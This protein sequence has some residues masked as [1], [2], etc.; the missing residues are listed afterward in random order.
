LGQ[1]VVGYDISFIPRLL[2]TFLGSGI[3]VLGFS[4]LQIALQIVIAD[5]TTLQWRPIVST[6]S[7]GGWYLCVFTVSSAFFTDS[8]STVLTS[9]LYLFSFILWVYG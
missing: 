7:T 2:L 6:L 5:I 1:A 3:W 9:T 4:G 8:L